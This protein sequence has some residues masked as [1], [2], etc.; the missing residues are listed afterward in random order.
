MHLVGMSTLLILLSFGPGYPILGARISQTTSRRM[1]KDEGPNTERFAKKLQ[2]TMMDGMMT[3]TMVTLLLMMLLPWQ[4]SCRLPHGHLRTNRHNSPCM[5]G[6]L[7]R[8]NSSWA[9]KQPYHHMVAT[10]LSWQSPLSW[11]SEVWL[12]LGILLFGREQS[13]HG[14]S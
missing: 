14:R 2:S 10:L 5:T 9:T 8:S 13:H 11:Q 3:F 7:T 6:I 4:Q 1:I 12:K